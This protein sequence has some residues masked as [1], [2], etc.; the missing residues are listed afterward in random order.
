MT[1]PKR[2]LLTPI[3][4]PV[5]PVGIVVI[6]AMTALV[7]LMVSGRG[8]PPPRF[9]LNRDQGSVDP[10]SYPLWRQASDWLADRRYVV[11]SFDDGPWGQGVD[12]RILRILHRHGAHAIFFVI[13]DHLDA[14]REHVLREI[15]Q[16][17][18]VIGNHTVDHPFLRRLNPSA[19]QHQIA[20][21]SARISQ[22]TGHRPQFFRPPFGQSSAVIEKVV[23]S[24]GMAQVLWDANSQDSWQREP[25][26]ILHWSLTETKNRYI[27]LMHDSPTTASALDRLLTTLQRRGYRFVT[28]VPAA[29]GDR[30]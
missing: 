20:D 15:E 13:C 11:L 21:C 5:R 4:I 6:L 2:W 7:L 14:S 25:G 12:E 22:I 16:A 26:E 29:T 30:H 24:A 1:N 9:V 8:L 23:Q 17:G 3:R 10:L 18:D 28:P 27:L 19:L